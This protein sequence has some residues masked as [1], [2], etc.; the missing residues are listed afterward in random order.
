MS[1]INNTTPP[2]TPNLLEEQSKTQIILNPETNYVM[3]MWND[4][5]L[6]TRVTK[7]IKSGKFR[8]GNKFAI[9]CFE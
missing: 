1:E 4:N 9:E 8:A 6:M 7:K 5:K 2:E 3:T